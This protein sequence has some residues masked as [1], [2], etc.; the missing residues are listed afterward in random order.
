[1]SKLQIPLHDTV[2]LKLEYDS[3][4]MLGFDPANYI[5]KL[6][7]YKDKSKVAELLLIAE[8]AENSFIFRMTRD[9]ADT[10]MPGDYYIKVTSENDNEHYT[11]ELDYEKI[12]VVN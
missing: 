7:F 11:Y 3:S 5:N 10:L 8:L 1:M 12:E 9:D 4:S 2:L 6:W